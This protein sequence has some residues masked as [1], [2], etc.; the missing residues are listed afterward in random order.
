[1]S[2]ATG[3]RVR[4]ATP[5]EA[6]AVA[7]AVRELLTELDG[8]PP[9]AASMEAAARTL[10]EEPD[11][12]TVLVADA[13]DAL[14]GVLAASWQLAIHVPGRYALIQDLWVQRDWRSRAV[15]A[16]LLDALFALAAQREVVRV[17]VGIPREDFPRFE[18]TRRFY[19]RNGFEALGTRMR[20]V[21]R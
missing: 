20:R 16:S 21:L 3:W 15:G 19:A 10:A 13:D 17:E 9:N 18:A 11:A 14:V 6:P 2:D 4:A 7:A 1:M 12:G 5:A 8:T